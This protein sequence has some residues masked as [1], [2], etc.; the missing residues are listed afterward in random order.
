MGIKYKKFILY[1]MN[2]Y[3]EKCKECP[4]FSKIGIEGRCELG[5]MDGQDMR[6]FCGDRKYSNCHIESDERVKIVNL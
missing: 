1:E 5:Y 3:P 2:C 6:D 4:A